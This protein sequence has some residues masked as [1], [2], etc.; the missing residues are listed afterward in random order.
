MQHRGHISSAPSDGMHASN[1][2]GTN[3]RTND[4]EDIGS[5]DDLVIDDNGRVVAI[6]VSVGGF[7]GMGQKDV[8]I[9]WD[10]VTR[11]G[12]SDKQELRVDVTRDDLRA[13]PTFAGR[14]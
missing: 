3:V 6:L 8:A 1:L 14:N 9:G 11:S 2:I 13:A 4:N 10:N 12:S 5:V 7:L